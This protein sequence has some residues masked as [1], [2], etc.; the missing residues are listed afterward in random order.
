MMSIEEGR[1]LNQIGGFYAKDETS[2]YYE[3]SV[4]VAVDEG[5]ELPGVELTLANGEVYW[6]TVS[7]LGYKGEDF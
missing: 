3:H 5:Y 7:R 1:I 4:R 6:I 2:P